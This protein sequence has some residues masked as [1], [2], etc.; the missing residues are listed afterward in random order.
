[1][2]DGAAARIPVGVATIARGV[3]AAL[4][5]VR[6]PTEAIHRD[7]QRLVGFL[8]DGAVRHGAG[9]EAL[10]DRFDPLH[11]VERDRRGG[12]LELDQSPQRGFSPRL[13]VDQ[14]RVLAVHVVLA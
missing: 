9:G 8:A 6:F 2:L 3:L 1:M 5:G 7:R 11:L 14:L 12:R 10:E 13:V 4:A